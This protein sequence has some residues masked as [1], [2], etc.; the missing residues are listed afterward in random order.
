ML[1][2]TT[3]SSQLKNKHLPVTWTVCHQEGKTLLLCERVKLQKLRF[4]DSDVRNKAEPSPKRG[5][6]SN[7][8]ITQRHRFGVW[9][10]TLRLFLSSNHRTGCLACGSPKQKCGGETRS[11]CLTRQ[12]SGRPWSRRFCPQPHS[13]AISSFGGGDAGSG[14]DREILQESLKQGTSRRCLRPQ[15][16]F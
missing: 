5:I 16:T 14:E 12:T 13:S 10:V 9:L 3:A 6:F 2:D 15:R 4:H 11:R 8:D 1:R 7:N